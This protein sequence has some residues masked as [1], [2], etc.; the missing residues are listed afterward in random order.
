MIDTKPSFWNECAACLVW[1]AV[2]MGICTP[3]VAIFSGA[4][5]GLPAFIG[6]AFAVASLLFGDLYLGEA[7]D[8]L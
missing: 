2:F 5:G 1:Y 7:H 3:T 6:G 4:I 8:D